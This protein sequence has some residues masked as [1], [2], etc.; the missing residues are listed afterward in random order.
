MPGV[1]R[2]VNVFCWLGWNAPTTVTRAARR[3]R[4]R[5][6]TA[7]GGREARRRRAGRAQ[8][9]PRRLVAERAEHDDHPH[10]RRAAAARARGTACTC[11]APRASACSRAA[12]S[13]PP[14]RRRRRAA[15]GRRRRATDSAW[16]AKPVRCSDANRKSPDRSPVNTRPVRLPP[17]AAGARPDEQ[18]PGARVAEARAP[19]GPST[20]RRGTRPAS[21]AR[22]PRATRPAAGTRGTSTISAVERSEGSIGAARSAMPTG[23]APLPSGGAGPAPR[24]R[25]RVVG[26]GPQA[27]DD[28]Q[29]AR[30]A[31]RSRG[32]RDVAARARRPGSRAR[33]R[34]TASTSSSCSPATARSTRPPTGCCTPTPRSRRCPAARPTSTR[35]RSASRPT[36]STRP[37]SCCASLGARRDEAHRRRPREPPAVP[38]QHRHRLRRRGDPPGRA[39]RRA[40]APSLASAAH[41]GRVRGLLPQRG[42]AH[43][44]S[45]SSSTPAS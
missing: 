6:R 14:R 37:T 7:A 41:R 23:A 4:A 13:A 19:A 3:P 16:F 10:L 29:A 39:L 43:A 40:E 28:P 1:S 33:P 18:E 20:P 25:D 31:A 38:V 44:G 17:C 22:P 34:T 30:R 8:R 32:R 42:H 27:G 11:R 24:Q 2:P 35:A 36:R 45:T 26:H 12:R 15:R 9:R 21:R 5:A